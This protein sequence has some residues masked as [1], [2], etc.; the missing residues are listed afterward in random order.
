MNIS[1]WLYQAAL[2]RP[3]RIAI[4]EGD[5]AC[6]TYRQFARRSAS[7]GAYLANEHGVSKGDRVAIFARNCV[8]YLEV[9]HGI[10][11]VGAIAVPINHKLHPR[12]AAWI[13]KNA[14]AKVVITETGNVFSEF[15]E[16]NFGIDASELAIGNSAL[17][18]GESR[19]EG[20]AREAALD[21]PL[22]VATD[23]VAWLFYTSGTTGRPKGVM[24]THGNL[25]AMALTYPLDVDP[26]LPDDH[27]LYAAPMSHGAGLYNFHSIRAGLCHAV[28]P[29]HGFDPAEIAGL[30]GELG[31]LVFFAAPTM[32]KRLVAYARVSG[33]RGEGIRSIIYGGGPMYAADIR[34]A[35]EIFG[36]RFIQIYGQGESPMT[37]T[38]LPRDLVADSLHPRA[39]QR[40][41]SVGL[42]Q[43]CVQVR[44][45]D[46]SMRDCPVGIAGEIV[47]K[48]DTVMKGYWCD[49]A[50]TEKTIRDG[51]LMTGDL[52]M[53]DEDGFLSL[54][55]RSKDVIISGGSNIY[56]REVEEVLL[57]H[58]L[59]FEV[60]VIGI[61]SAEWGE[62]VVAFVVLQPDATCGP[63]VLDAWCKSRIA[64]FKKPKTYR[65]VPELPKN[66]Y[67]KILKTDLRK[68]LAAQSGTARNS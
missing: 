41:A 58:D 54:T 13:L 35:L 21:M 19:N 1:Y 24:L 68:V 20:L 33:Y 42:A 3:E 44:V 8:Q 26:V 56:P 61:P 67:G 55:D 37:I 4:R 10:L 50:A 16:E 60:S 32:I 27:V 62:E 2:A 30:A 6:A 49:D 43:S 31:N 39:E 45:V 7:F 64:S 52:G 59:V 63:G 14:E 40:R 36:P 38:A 34:E 18:H 46:D 53:F 15:S 57:A 51:W 65:F 48:G 23:D 66:G 9:L 12:E 5:K 47:V 28:P 25:R 29:S 11:W 17:V 22:Q